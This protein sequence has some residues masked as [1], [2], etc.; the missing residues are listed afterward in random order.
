MIIF[1]S[2]RK[3]T[4]FIMVYWVRLGTLV[5]YSMGVLMIGC[6]GRRGTMYI[7]FLIW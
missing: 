2:I 6:T 1:L 4:K 5:L 7:S 3:V